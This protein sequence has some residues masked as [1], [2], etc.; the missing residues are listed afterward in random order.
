MSDVLKKRGLVIGGAVVAVI[1]ATVIILLAAK[2]GGSDAPSG[3]RVKI[4]LRGQPVAEIHMNGKN[5]GTTPKT[6][7]VARGTTPITFEAYFTVE[8]VAIGR[9]AQKVE[10]WRHT[11]QVVPDAEQS[12]DFRIQDATMIEQGVELRET[13]RKRDRPQPPPQN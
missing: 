5:I 9:N 12:V 6:I 4:E 13:A 7:V 10:T 1:V 3:E 11:K 2:N 8:K